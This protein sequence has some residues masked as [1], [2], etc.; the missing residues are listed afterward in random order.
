AVISNARAA[1]VDREYLKTRGTDGVYPLMYYNHNLDFLASA[2]MMTGQFKEAKQAADIVVAN[3]TPMIAQMPMIEPFGA[4]TMYVL[5]RFARW[6]DVLALPAPDP[7]HAL[8]T[9][10]SHFGRGVAQAARGNVAAAEAERTS[11]A[12][13]RGG[14][15]P[16]SDWGYNKAR[17]M[18]AITDAVLEAWI[19]RATRDDDAAIAAWKRAVAAEDATSYDEPADWFYPTRESL[20]AALLRAQRAPEAAQ[21]F[22]DDLARNPKNGRSL[23][24]LWQAQIATKDPAAAAT[25]KQFREAWK[26]A[27][28]TIRIA[29]F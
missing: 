5:M 22:R 7:K 13:A 8:L 21:V 18:L 1:A 28:V 25:Q 11:Y 12:V 4:K 29:D 9:T 27:D 23:F 19:A 20:G 2:A 16:D 24:G 26:N 15:A 17:N 6:D 10:L 3:A 14:V